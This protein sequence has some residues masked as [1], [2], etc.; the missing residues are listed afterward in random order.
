MSAL[1]TDT[2]RS[3]LELD[4]DLGAGMSPA[5]ERDARDELRAGLLELPPGPWE[6][7]WPAQGGHL[8]FLLVDGVIARE[9]TA[10]DTV[11]PELLSPGDV[12]RPW[13][14][15]VASPLLPLEVRWHVLAEARVVVLDAEFAAGLRRFPEVGVAL[16]ERL[17]ARA[18]RLATVQAIGR[19]GPVDERLVA[20]FWH[21]AD[22][23]GRVA[24]DGVRIPLT[25]SHRLLGQLVGAR[26]PTVSAALGRLS[27]GGR[28]VRR[29]DGTWLLPGA[30]VAAPRGREPVEPRRRLLPAAASLPVPKHVLLAR[31]A[32]GRRTI[33]ELTEEVARLRGVTAERTQALHEV[34]AVS[35]DICRTTSAIRR[36]R[37][38][39]SA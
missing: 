23:W 7:D 19:L 36:R 2:A 8:G 12:A 33:K 11:I 4:P 21:L 25:L 3:V 9:V 32:T 29:A 10:Q 35:A 5:R 26:R 27:A 24:P 39:E 28:V 13:A 15:D 16:A 20:L 14:V 6:P 31:E 38:G 1:H 22:R 34:C 17:E 30:P 18:Q 37:V